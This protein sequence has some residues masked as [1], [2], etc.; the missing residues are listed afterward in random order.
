[1]TMND[2]GPKMFISDPYIINLDKDVDR[3][4]IISKSLNDIHSPYIRF[5]AIDGKQLSE[6]EISRYTTWFGR[7]FLLTHSMLGCALS[8]YTAINKAKT[9]ILANKPNIDPNTTWILILEDDAI[10]TPNY[11][12]D[13]AKLKADL[14]WLYANNRMEYDRID[15]LRLCYPSKHMDATPSAKLFLTIPN[16]A[17]PPIEHPGHMT[18]SFRSYFLAAHATSYIVKLSSVDKLLNHLNTQK[19]NT[20]VDLE[21]GYNKNIGTYFVN[22]PIIDSIIDNY[23]SSSNLANTYPKSITT[24]I[25]ILNRI[26]LLSNYF[27]FGMIQP[28][29][30]F[31]LYYKIANV[32]LFLLIF[33]LIIWLIARSMGSKWNP[34]PYLLIFWIVDTVLFYRY[35][36]GVDR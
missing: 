1:M 19:I 35:P 3:W 27:T 11:K 13:M 15:T 32:W 24:T 26:G 9:Q 4:N 5:P 22:V 23:D 6:E 28:C 31:N 2:T 34:W 16:T 33:I 14:A 8:H 18:Y 29:C 30:G 10:I 36:T 7:T 21:W 25:V 12:S 20:H 17:Y